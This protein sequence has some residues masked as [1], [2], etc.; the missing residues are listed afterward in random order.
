MTISFLSQQ[1][2]MHFLLLPGKKEVR[3]NC[4]KMTTVKNNNDKKQQQQQN[5]TYT[6]LVQRL[7]AEIAVTSYLVDS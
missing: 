3:P 5:P 6:K 7:L 2:A 4:E 1:V